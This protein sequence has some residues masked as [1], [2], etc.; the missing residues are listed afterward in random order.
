VTWLGLGPKYLLWLGLACALVVFALYRLRD[1]R[2]TIVV[3]SLA[4][5]KAQLNQRSYTPQSL[6]R[7]LSIALQLLLLALLLLAL[8]DPARAPARDSLRH[9]LVLVDTSASM[10]TLENSSA[11]G[12]TTRL[13]LAQASLLRFIE[14]LE[15]DTQVLLATADTDVVPVLP[16]TDDRLRLSLA[17]S[18]L[19][20]RPM[21]SRFQN[22]LGQ[23]AE[24]LAGKS[25]AKMLFVTDAAG[26]ASDTIEVPSA[27]RNIT[28]SALLIGKARNNVA[29][30]GLWPRRQLHQ[31]DTVELR[32][33]VAN[34]GTQAQSV[35]IDFFAGATRL[36]TE[37]LDLLAGEVKSQ[38][39][40]LALYAAQEI[41]AK[42]RPLPQ[43][44][45]ALLLD[46]VAYAVVPNPRKAKLLVLSGGDLYLQAA[47]LAD[48]WTIPQFVSS[49]AELSHAKFDALIVDGG[50]LPQ[51][52]TSPTL[53]L[54]PKE[55][56]S[57]VAKHSNLTNFGFDEWDKLHPILTG[58][59]LFDVQVTSGHA[60]NVSATDKVLARSQ[61]RPIL[62]LS[63][64]DG[65]PLVVLGFDPKASD[66]VLRPA[67][68]LFVQQ[69]SAYLLTTQAPAPVAAVAGTLTHFAQL[70]P[71]QLANGAWQ[72]QHPSGKVVPSIPSA[73]G[74][75]FVPEELG[76]YRL[77][78]AGK[79][80]AKEVIA[81]NL[82]SEAESRISPAQT[83]S[84]GAKALS[85]PSLAPR[86]AP[87]KL[88][89]W[90]LATTIAL[91]LIE[92]ASYHRRVTV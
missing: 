44:A 83:L 75:T 6:R 24:L 90:L 41:T 21:P 37:T 70:V 11:I 59:E 60:L 61:K 64:Q 65:F 19:T 4:H 46:N 79:N 26:S 3:P 81:V 29:L 32:Y 10:D 73:G 20:S 57:V 84:L 54:A 86:N 67:W 36:H 49:V 43:S 27:L 69:A 34:Y 78:A 30:L 74:A 42:L 50:S 31:L 55:N 40:A 39:L 56:S 92:W 15:P 23:A 76:F 2:K 38:I 5:F 85:A 77:F 66:F 87:P 12:G 53:W 51:P 91:L 88:G 35:T 82:S 25:H 80:D 62:T 33:T 9:V 89:F 16:W 22:C 58:L 63:Q 17:V 45:D 72:M 13:A 52:L 18:H 28:T 71:D 7:W 47:V 14:S 68:P 1:Y 48:P 8:G